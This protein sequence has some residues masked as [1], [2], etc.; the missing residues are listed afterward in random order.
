[1]TFSCGFY[2]R[3]LAEPF[4]GISEDGTF[5]AL[6]DAT[7]SKTT[8]EGVRFDGSGNL[9]YHRRSGFLERADVSRIGESGFRPRPE[10]L[11]KTGLRRSVRGIR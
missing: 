1:M 2:I 7:F 5:E 10:C 8:C 3:N 6:A 11:T 9:S 4:Y